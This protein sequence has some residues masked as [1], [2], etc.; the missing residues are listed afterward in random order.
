MKTAWAKNIRVAASA[1]AAT[2]ALCVASPLS[3]HGTAAGAAQRQAF[4]T[5]R[6]V[7]A[8]SPLPGDLLI[9]DRGND[10]ILI[11]TPDKRIIWQMS[12]ANLGGPRGV[13]SLGPDDAFFTP[14]HK[15]IIV[16]EEDDHAIAVVDIA[17][18]KVVWSYGHPGVPGSAPGYL[19]TPDDA[20]MLPSGLVTVA[21]I[22]NQRI[23]FIDPRTNRV[24][25]QYGT[26][27]LR[28][29]NP[30]V[31]FASPNGDTPLPGGGMIVTEIGG[32]YADVLDK[33]GHVLY[34][35]HFPDV[36]YPSDTQMMPNGDLLTVDYNTPGRVEM[37]NRQ[38]KVVWEY[39]RTAGSGELSHPS[40]ALPLPN[41]NIA[42]NDDYNDRVVV[43][44]PRRNRIVWQYG[45]TGV[46]G[47]APG[48]LNIPDGMDLMPADVQL[49]RAR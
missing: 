33:H 32:S 39:Y 13:N 48:Y 36:A 4:H 20:Y 37:V 10:R 43:I 24:V 45:H 30:P 34:T 11:V 16:N 41:G 22:R 49:G 6:S 47:A 44:D 25:K 40:L 42:V 1:L 21:D 19:H 28:R 8:G 14:D 27:G 17:T 12:F 29:H 5:A 26:T 23:L 38:G 2:A 9:A 15:H 18:K 3:A 31:S 35:V 7:Q 46:P